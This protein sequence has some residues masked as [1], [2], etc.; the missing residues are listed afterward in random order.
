M[1]RIACIYRITS[2]TGKVYIGQTWDYKQRLRCY[3]GLVKGSTGPILFKS[4]NKHGVEMHLFEIIYQFPNDVT[5]S[6]LNTY[7][8]FYISAYKACGFKMLNVTNGGAGIYGYK[9]TE[10]TLSVMR[11]NNAGHKNPN[12]GKGCFGITNG[13]AREVQLLSKNNELI[14]EYKTVTEAARIL[15]LKRTSISAVLNGYNK[16]LHGFIWKYKQQQTA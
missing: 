5:Q 2:P 4:F 9:H 6:V 14:S 7:E 16:A 13:R 8:V 11:I 3:Y 15:G 1:K 12:Y 10:K